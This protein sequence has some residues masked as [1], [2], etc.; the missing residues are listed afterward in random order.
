MTKVPDGFASKSDVPNTI[1]NEEYRALREA[2]AQAER[3]QAA[4]HV[5]WHLGDL[6]GQQPGSFTEKLLDTWAR[7]DSENHLRLLVAFPVLG[8][9]VDIAKTQ[10]RDALAAWGG[11]E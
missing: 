4:R 9:A 5:L 3:E 10:G 7:A 1:T 11:I 2:E 8:V 6:R